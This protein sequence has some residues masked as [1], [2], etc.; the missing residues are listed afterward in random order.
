MERIRL[1]A[2]SRYPRI[3]LQPAEVKKKKKKKMGELQLQ[4][5]LELRFSSILFISVSMSWAFVTCPRCTI[6]T[7]D[8]KLQLLR[9]N[10]MQIIVAC[11]I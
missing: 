9:N 6:C 4:L 3:L 11:L 8:Q 10:S 7:S 5:Q 2:L 1:S